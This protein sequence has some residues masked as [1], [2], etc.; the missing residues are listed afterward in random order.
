MSADR[1][2]LQILVKDDLSRFFYQDSSL[3]TTA[4]DAR[5]NWRLGAGRAESLVESG[6]ESNGLFQRYPNILE[7][8]CET[9][10]QLNKTIKF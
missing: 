3:P 6:F 7:T 1:P 5:K 10:Q 2:Y 8:S 4:C 9:C